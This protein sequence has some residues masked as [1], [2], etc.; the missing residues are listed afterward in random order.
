MENTSHTIIRLQM[1]P[2]VIPPCFTPLFSQGVRIG[3]CLECS[4][5][6]LICG[7]LGV[8]EDYLE[9]RVQTIFLNG[10]PVDD[11]DR[12]MVGDGATIALSAAMPGLAGAVL[13]KGGALA[14]LRQDITY[15]N[16]GRVHETCRGR[17]TLKL[18]NMTGREVGPIL[19]A[20]GILI[21]GAG[22]REV[23]ARCGD[24][25]RKGCQQAQWN[26]SAIGF[27]ELAARIEADD[28]FL[29]QVNAA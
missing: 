12:A 14:A 2:A 7:Q 26:G 25:L 16:Q 5:K 27:G 28:P 20:F 24:L 18:F 10:R 3:A 15:Q 6:E 11:A 9:N 29:L 4:V 17:V 13:R 21:D 22:L 19:L 8:P 23:F 1:D